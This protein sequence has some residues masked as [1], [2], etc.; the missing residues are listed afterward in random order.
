M[1]SFIT[2]GTLTQGSDVRTVVEGAA[3]GV[4]YQL[5]IGAPFLLS[6]PGA[7]VSRSFDFSR[8]VCCL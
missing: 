5:L 1:S 7:Y 3:L 2:E 8:Q 6:A 4:A